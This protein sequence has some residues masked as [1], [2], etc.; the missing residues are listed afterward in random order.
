MIGEL[1]GCESKLS[2]HVR[3][4]REQKGSPRV[5]KSHVIASDKGRIR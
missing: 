1:G 4:R 3:S 5:S 2:E